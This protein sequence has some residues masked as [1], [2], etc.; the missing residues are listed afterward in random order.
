MGKKREKT[1]PSEKPGP[2][3][4]VQAETGGEQEIVGR[5]WELAEPLCAAEGV[6]LIHVEFQREAGGRILRLYIEKDGGVSLDD[7]TCVS[8][9]LSDTL[10]IKLD[11]EAPYT[12]EVSS[13]GARRPVSRP[14]DFERFRGYLIKIRLARPKNGQKNFTGILAGYRDQTVWLTI[15]GETIGID[16][17]EITKARLVNSV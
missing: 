16:P 8:R 6:E 11:T 1:A 3:R 10:D 5:V 15:G 13:P 17:A 14:A 9:Q 2:N 7:C 12:L 4:R